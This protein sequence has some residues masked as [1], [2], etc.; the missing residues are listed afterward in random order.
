MYFVRVITL[1]AGPYRRFK[2]SKELPRVG[3]KFLKPQKLY[4]N[5]SELNKNL[6]KYILKLRNYKSQPLTLAEY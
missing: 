5:V 4:F 2:Q 3:N 1:D 6:K